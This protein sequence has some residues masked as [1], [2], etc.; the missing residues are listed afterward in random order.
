ML[1]LEPALLM[2]KKEE[3]EEMLIMA[4]EMQWRPTVIACQ[5]FLEKVFIF[6]FNF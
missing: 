4:E 3:V 5:L 2:K 6:F 1:G